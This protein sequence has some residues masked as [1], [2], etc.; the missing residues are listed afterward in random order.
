[1]YQAAEGK[2]LPLEPSEL[3]REGILGI[4]RHPIMT[5]F[6]MM[7]WSCA[8]PSKGRLVFNAYMTAYIVVAVF[9]FEEP[10]L[11]AALG[12]AYAQYKHQ[13]AAFVPYLIL[14]LRAQTD[15]PHP[16][17][18]LQRARRRPAGHPNPMCACRKGR[19]GRTRLFLLA[20]VARERQGMQ[21][22]ELRGTA[23]TTPS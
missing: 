6:L 22:I 7:F 19:S 2:T 16:P 18:A 4:V 17:H 20:C 1:M 3:S 13:V 21:G 5:G 14:C 9:G 15:H 12:T 11:E 10:A 23:K 8:N